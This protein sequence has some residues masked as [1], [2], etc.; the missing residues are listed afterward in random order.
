MMHAVCFSNACVC[1]QVKSF[2]LSRPV[3]SRDAKTDEKE[4]V[5]AEDV[6]VTVGLAEVARQL[7]FIGVA[8][9]PSLVV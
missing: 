8:R 7:D 3:K 1:F 4:N 2:L 5:A 9:R 6:V